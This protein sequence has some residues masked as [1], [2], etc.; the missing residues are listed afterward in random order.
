MRYLIAAHTDVGIKKKT[1]QDS[2]MI[3]EAQ[4][5]R[6]R[7][8][9]CVLCD[10]MGGLSNGELASATV[11]RA[12]EQWFETEFP[13]LLSEFS[14][15][16]LKEQ[17]I[18]IT[19]GLN[20]RL[21]SH[22]AGTGRRMGTTLVGLLLMENHFYIINVGDSRAYALLDQ[23]YQLTKDQSLVQQQIDLGRLSPEQAEIHP[24]RNV[25]LQCI[26]ASEVVAP[27]F[28]EGMIH[29][30][31]LFLLCS[32]GFR[33]VVSEEEIFAQLSPDNLW[34]EQ[35]M[36]ERLIWLTELEKTRMEVDNISAVTVKVGQEE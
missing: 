10:G 36:K 11:I 25:L 16:K 34:D 3:K 15:E 18:H 33:H 35:T 24:Q 19:E 26:G 32:D 13:I 4:T 21:A 7:V 12:F 27:D 5:K 31:T 2:Y 9:L 23:V 17:W 29:P 8:C 28:Y 6:G 14:F 1:N 20:Q 22:T 30:G